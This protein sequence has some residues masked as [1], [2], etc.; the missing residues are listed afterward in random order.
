MRLITATMVMMAVVFL[1]KVGD[2]VV[3]GGKYS[4]DMLI[5]ASIAKSEEKSEEKPDEEAKASDSVSEEKSS[6][7][8]S[9]EAGDG[10]AVHNGEAASDEAEAEAE[11]SLPINDNEKTYSK[12]EVDILQSLSRRREELDEREKSL[13]LREQ[14]LRGTEV[15]ID[16]KIQEL[17]ALKGELDTLL[18]QYNENEDTKI[19]SLVKIYENMKPKDAAAIFEQ[20]DMVILLKVVDQMQEKKVAPI[21]AKMNPT[22]AKEVTMSLARQKQLPDKIE[23]E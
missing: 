15:K 8:S 5:T 21:L 10:D 11:S 2:L 6:D 14:V 4:E 22:R 20:V 18:A 16:S 23:V 1:V 13:K 7:N 3:T 19:R 17:S 9:A 12:I